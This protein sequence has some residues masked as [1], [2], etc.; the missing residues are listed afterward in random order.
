MIKVINKY[1]IFKIENENYAIPV[2]DIKEIVR[3]TSFTPVPLAPDF[4]KGVINIRGRIIPLIDLRIKFGFNGKTIENDNCVFIILESTGTG[5]SHIIAIIVDNV[6]E[7]I[8]IMPDEIT[9]PIDL[10]NPFQTDFLSGT[11]NINDRKIQ[12][13]NSVDIMSMQYEVPA[14]NI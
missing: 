14:D 7:I 8:T 4:V 6:L 1:L 13:L 12:I 2:N 5:K 9:S 10:F 3:M 11:A